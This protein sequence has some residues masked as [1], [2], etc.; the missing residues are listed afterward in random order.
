M[1][2][3]IPFRSQSEQLANDVLVSA[4]LYPSDHQ[5]L[6]LAEREMRHITSIIITYLYQF[7]EFRRL[8]ELWRKVNDLFGT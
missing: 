5:A 4:G 1:E 8:A 6:C 7:P 2:I 3:P